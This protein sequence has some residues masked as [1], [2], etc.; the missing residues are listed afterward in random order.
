[1]S[2]LPADAYVLKSSDVTPLLDTV[3][4]LL[5]ERGS[6]PPDE[7]VD[8]EAPTAEPKRAPSRKS[9]ATAKPLSKR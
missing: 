9:K 5:A 6:A 7:T 1:M 2:T 8:S 3:K 4:S